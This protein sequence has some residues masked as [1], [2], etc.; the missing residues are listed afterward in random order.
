MERCKKYRKRAL[1]RANELVLPCRQSTN[2]EVCCGRLHFPIVKSGA[3]RQSGLCRYIDFGFDPI[4]QR[5]STK[6]QSLASDPVAALDAV[7]AIFT[8][9]TKL[10]LRCYLKVAPPASWRRARWACRTLCICQG[11]LSS[12]CCA[13]VIW[14]VVSVCCYRLICAETSG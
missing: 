8:A 2:P 12:R 5:S 3:P 1:A 11:F 6:R 10:G 14:A 13:F 4:Q 7:L 9:Y